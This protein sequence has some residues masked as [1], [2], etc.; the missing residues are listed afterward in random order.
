[1]NNAMMS[2]EFCVRVLRTRHLV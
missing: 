2:S 1:M